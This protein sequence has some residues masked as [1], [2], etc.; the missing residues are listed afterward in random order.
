MDFSGRN[1][2]SFG[3][4]S[5]ATIEISFKL[6]TAADSD[7]SIIDFVDIINLGQIFD[8]TTNTRVST[9]LLFYI[10]LLRVVVINTP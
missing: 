6:R 10:D 7:K 8:N 1:V 9:Y 5:R 4:G 3:N 2:Q